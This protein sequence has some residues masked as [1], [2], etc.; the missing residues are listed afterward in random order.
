M[1]MEARTL[2]PGQRSELYA[3]DVDYTGWS[4]SHR[5]CSSSPTRPTPFTTSHLQVSGVHGTRRM[6]P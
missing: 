3:V 6:S 1:K 4:Q 5:L 2:S